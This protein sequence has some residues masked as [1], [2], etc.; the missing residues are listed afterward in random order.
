MPGGS[1]YRKQTVDMKQFKVSCSLFNI[2][3][4]TVAYGTLCLLVTLLVAAT[5]LSIHSIH[6]G[7]KSNSKL[8][9]Y[10][11]RQWEDI[12][13]KEQT[14]SITVK[15]FP[16]IIKVPSVSYNCKISAMCNLQWKKG[17]FTTFNI[18]AF[19]IH[20]CSYS[21]MIPDDRYRSDRN[22]LVNSNIW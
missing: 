16:W 5:C 9:V 21:C 17:C 8:S 3:G 7:N 15:I 14:R 2:A 20:Y 13:W 11:V 6:V 22:M 19:K 18:W 10:K 1:D 4:C 12:L